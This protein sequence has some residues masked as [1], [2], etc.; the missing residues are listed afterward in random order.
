MLSFLKRYFV[1]IVSLIYL[2]WPIDILPDLFG[3]IGLIDDAGVLLL[4]VIAEVVRYLRERGTK[5]RNG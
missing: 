3:P 5:D 1:L 4:A 2:I